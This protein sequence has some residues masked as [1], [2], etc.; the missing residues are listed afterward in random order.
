ML[1]FLTQ[2]GGFHEENEAII[3]P[4]KF[5][6]LRKALSKAGV[7]GLTIT[8]AENKKAKKVCFAVQHFKFNYSLK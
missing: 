2:E 8:E 1:G 4:E 5:Q 3:R 7:G 6:S